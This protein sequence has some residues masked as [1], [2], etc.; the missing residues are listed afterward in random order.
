MCLLYTRLNAV[1]CWLHAFGQ[2][3]SHEGH[4]PDHIV[5]KTSVSRSDH[6]E[7]SPS[8][9]RLVQLFTPILLTFTLC[10]NRNLY[11]NY[12]DEMYMVGWISCKCHP[13]TL[14]PMYFQKV[15]W[16]RCQCIIH[17]LLGLFRSI[18]KRGTCVC[19]QRNIYTCLQSPQ[20]IYTYDYNTAIPFS[21][22]YTSD[23]SLQ[24]C[25]YSMSVLTLPFSFTFV[26]MTITAGRTSQIICQKSE[27]V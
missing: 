4:V 21:I 18:T 9:I 6:S 13:F 23:R 11:N 26:N 2:T 19:P 25:Y 20:S 1:F 22:V 16:V 5:S 14:N 27:T 12:V 24:Y 8:I 15:G 7:T 10:V 17:T 3:H